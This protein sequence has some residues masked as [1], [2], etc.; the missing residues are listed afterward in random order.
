MKNDEIHYLTALK[1]LI[2]IIDTQWN[3]INIINCQSWDN[4]CWESPPCKFSYFEI[5]FLAQGS[6]YLEMNGR[7]YNAEAGQVYFSDISL[8]SSCTSKSFRMCFIT[9]GTD[10]PILYEK[11]KQCFKSLSLCLQPQYPPDLERMFM[12]ITIETFVPKTFSNLNAKCSLLS[13]LM[14]LCRT[15]EDSYTE[16]PSPHCS[17]ERERLAGHMICYLNENS[18]RHITLNDLQKVFD[19]CSRSLN[20]IFRSAT[21]T[22][23]MKYLIRLRIEK[24]K[25]LLRLTSME[26][27]DI[28]LETG[29]CDCQHFSKTF[30]SLEGISPRQY[31]QSI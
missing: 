9:L 12:D 10:D 19:T 30:N 14:I 20:F 1:E 28:A 16:K 31:R 24:A 7:R 2:E 6:C 23:I 11:L 15:I 8:Y 13:I 27:T 17:P 5:S 22:T 26:I 21:G 25:R 29:F 4:Q 3:H 18:G